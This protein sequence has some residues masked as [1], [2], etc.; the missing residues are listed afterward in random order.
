MIRENCDRMRVLLLVLLASLHSLGLCSESPARVDAAE[1]QAE[2]DQLR[3]EIDKFTQLLEETKSERSSIESELKQNEKGISELIKK[4]QALKEQLNKGRE[5][6]ALCSSDSGNF[7][8]QNPSNSNMSSGRFEQPIR[9]AARNT[10]KCCSI[11]K[12]PTR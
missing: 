10:S 3:S 11:R 2:L 6:I 5:K 8:W 12:I 4:I 1:I 7:C 9:S